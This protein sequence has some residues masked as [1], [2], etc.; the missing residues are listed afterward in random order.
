MVWQTLNHHCFHLDDGVDGF[1]DVDDGE[2]D[3]DDGDLVHVHLVAN[4][5]VGDVG[6]DHW[7]PLKVWHTLQ[8]YGYE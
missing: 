7:M 5:E 3:V 1:N 6:G 4:V 8:T 2:D